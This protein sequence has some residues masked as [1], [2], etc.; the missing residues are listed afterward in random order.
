MKVRP[1]Y[2]SPGFS[3]QCE[4]EVHALAVGNDGKVKFC[5]IRDKFGNQRETISW[6]SPSG[7]TITEPTMPPDWECHLFKHD[8]IQMLMGPQFISKDPEAYLR[9]VEGE[10]AQQGKF[11]DRLNQLQLTDT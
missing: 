10:P 1:K 3:Q 9:L 4:Y 8:S 11:S 7:F 6:L 2:Y 5:V